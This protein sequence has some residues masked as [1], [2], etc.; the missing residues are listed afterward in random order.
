[1]GTNYQLLSFLYR[2]KRNNEDK[3][4][5]TGMGLVTLPENATIEK[6][7]EVGA[8]GGKEKMEK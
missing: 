7:V 8:V 1:M 2:K 6:K 4:D 3:P 5:D